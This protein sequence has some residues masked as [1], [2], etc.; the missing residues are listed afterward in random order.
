[1]DC[2]VCH[3]PNPDDSRFCTH[4]GTQIVPIGAQAAQA[5]S[6]VV[7]PRPAPV[8]PSAQPAFAFAGAGAAATPIPSPAGAGVSFDPGALVQR[9]LR[10]TL[11]PKAEWPA[12][13]AEPPSLA[14][15]IVGCVLPLAAIQSLLSFVH[16]AVIG[17]G[18]PFAGNVRMPLGSSLTTAL[19][20][21][22]FAFIGLFVFALIVNGWARFFGG[23]S[24][25]GEAFKVAAYTSVPA[26]I[27]AFF[28]VLGALGTLIGLLAAFY[29]IYVLYLGLPVVMRS[30]RER[31]VGYTV[32]VILTGM[33]LGLVVGGVFAAVGGATHSFM[34]PSAEASAD[35]SAERSAA[36]AGNVLGGLLGT[37][38]KGKAA[39][40]DA[41]GNLARAGAQMEQTE[42][43]Q[44][45]APRPAA[46]P[47]APAGN[48]DA[49]IPNGADP[50]NAGA[51]VG[52]LL[53]A[54]G[55]ALGGS[56]RV[57]PVD[58]RNLAALLPSSMNGL[59]RG[60]VEGAN[61]QAMG[62]Q[63]SSAN[64][65]YGGGGHRI[66]LKIADI[67]G[68]S[69]LLGIAE[70]LDQT[71][72]AQTADGFERDATV[73][74]HRVHEKYSSGR[75]HGELQVIVAR[76]F[77]IDLDGDGIEMAEL[78]QALGQVDLAR[79]ASMKNDGAQK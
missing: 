43:A 18:V 41:I 46:A 63:G 9:L 35:V 26:W 54:L 51:A 48:V 79:L 71:T 40:G 39:L 8:P 33:L 42:R 58:F 11:Q 2:P 74:G 59:S 57:T 20:G 6:A 29:S 1:M 19:M 44:A 49:A 60:P 3:T 23:R 32:A 68:V 15:V 65:T 56:Q 70:K 62:V 5:T 47:P 4:C 38:N 14:R 30:A 53:S 17:V 34:R 77:A 55:G 24:D 75:R 37:D 61:K 27:G 12:I 52:G 67:S 10:I 25:L 13:A 16:M 69:G 73:D 45:N 7:P 78:E 72:D 21:F 64:A 28:G 66:Q 36:A 31:A 76:R 22:V 50:A